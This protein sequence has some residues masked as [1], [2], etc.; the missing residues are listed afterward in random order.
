MTLFYTLYYIGEIEPEQLGFFDE[1]WREIGFS[2]GL[3]QKNVV[4]RVQV[5]GKKRNL[6]PD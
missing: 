2:W 4:A 3:R 5:D 1:K 6:R